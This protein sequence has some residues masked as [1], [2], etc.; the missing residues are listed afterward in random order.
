MGMQTEMFIRF[1]EVPA[2]GRSYNAE[3]N[4]S[5]AGVSCWRATLNADGDTLTVTV[6]TEE[7]MGGTMRIEDRPVYAIAGT[8]LH[9]RGSD[10][11]PLLADLTDVRRLDVE[12]IDYCIDGQEA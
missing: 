12:V 2:D 7:A 4:R 10:G 11:E 9:Q 3:D 1:G 8:L 6:P 5:E